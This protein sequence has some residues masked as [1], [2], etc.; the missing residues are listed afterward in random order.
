MALNDQP[1]WFHSALIKRDS[2]GH[3]HIAEI[4]LY[5]KL[6]CI[7]EAALCWL[8]LL[9]QGKPRI[10]PECLLDMKKSHVFI[11][12]GIKCQCFSHNE[13]FSSAFPAWSHV[14]S[15]H[16]FR[17]CTDS[18]GSTTKDYVLCLRDVTPVSRDG[19]NGWFSWWLEWKK[20]G[21]LL[22]NIHYMMP[23]YRIEPLITSH[24]VGVKADPSPVLM[25]A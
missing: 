8:L 20:H 3:C 16:R 18:D 15:R 24:P 21:S 23:V 14:L 1:D 6:P 13:N 25:F 4:I 10:H 7:L 9:S 19:V 22:C 11:Y 5:S 17:T 2:S 12:F